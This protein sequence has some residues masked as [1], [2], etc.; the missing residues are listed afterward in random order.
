M[1]SGVGEKVRL[2]PQ[3]EEAVRSLK[4]QAAPFSKSKPHPKRPGRKPGAQYG[5]RAG[6]PVPQ[7]ID[8]E[9]PVPLPERCLS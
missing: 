9:F 8:E 5:Q 6:R 2:R 3:L 7:R 1:N 4:R